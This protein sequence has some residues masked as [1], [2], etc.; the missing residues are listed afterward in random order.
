[1]CVTTTEAHTPR[2]HAPQKVKTPQREAC[3]PQL[4]NSLSPHLEKVHE[5]QQRPNAAKNKIKTVFYRH[6][7]YT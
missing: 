4:E 1:M 2:V 5:Q 3:A 7:T 6:E